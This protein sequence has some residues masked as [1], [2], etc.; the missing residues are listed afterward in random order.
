[1]RQIKK[2]LLNKR[3]SSF[4]LIV[5]VTLALALIFCGVSEYFRLMVIAQGVR[6]A[7]QSAVI[8]TVNDNYDDVYHGVREGYSG[9]YQPT[10]DDFEES[11][12]YG[13]IYSRLDSLLG[14]SSSGGYHEKRNSDGELEFRIWSL[15]VDIENAPL[16]SGDQA[17]NRFEADCTIELE[18]PVSFRGKLLPS[19]RITVKTTAGFVPRF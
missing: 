6:D 2:I 5:A 1:M 10:A 16:A 19:M 3:G 15:S 7:V 18:V 9:A 17:S 13:D 12:D 11:L 4:P 14:L 8:S